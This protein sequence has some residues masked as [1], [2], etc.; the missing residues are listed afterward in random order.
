MSIYEIIALVFSVLMC[1]PTL[2]SVTKFD[3]WW[4]RGFDFP[5]IQISFL[6]SL[7]IIDQYLSARFFRNLA[8]HC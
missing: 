8:L 4:I 6:I 3:H 7:V 2:A 5:R 1:I